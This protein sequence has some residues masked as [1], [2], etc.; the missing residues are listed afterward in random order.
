MGYDITGGLLFF[1]H[2]FFRIGERLFIAQD[3]SLENN[4]SYCIDT[5]KIVL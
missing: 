2:Q 5:A 4:A 1:T 3:V